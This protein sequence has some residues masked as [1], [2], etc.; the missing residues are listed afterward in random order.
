MAYKETIYLTQIVWNSET[1]TKD[2][3]SLGPLALEVEHSGTAIESRTGDDQ[4]SVM[5][6]IVNKIISCTVTVAKVKNVHALGTKASL[7][8]TLAKKDGTTETVTLAGMIL[9][10]VSPSQDRAVVGT[11]RFEFVH[12]SEDGSTVPFS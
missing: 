4:Y 9:R 6:A 12:E 7:V 1:W 10:S 3:A 8:A 11:C 2:G 5:T